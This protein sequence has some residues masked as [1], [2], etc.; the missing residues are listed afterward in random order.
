MD[1]EKIISEMSLEEKISFCTG[2]DMWH[3]KAMEKYGIEA[4]MM[5]DGPHGLRCQKNTGDNLGLNDS[6]PATC[7]PTAVTSGSSWDPELLYE[8]G[9]AIAEEALEY[10]VSTVLGPGVNIKRNPL[11]GRNFEYFSEDPHLAG[12]LAAGWIRGVQSEGVGTSLKH[13]ACN[14]QEYKRQNGNSIVDERAMHE[15]YLKPFETAVKEGHPSTVM[16]SYNQINGIYASDNRYLLT[17]VL[18]NDWG[19]DGMVVTDWGAM[20]DRI[21]GFKAGCDL[22]MPGGSKY[23]EKAVLKA[24][25]EGTLEEDDINRCLRRVLRFVENGLAGRR[26]YTFDREK[27]HALAKRIAD[28]G[29]VLLKNEGI[30]PLDKNE[31]GIIGNMAEMI[32]YQGSG[33]SHINPTKLDEIRDLWS[34]IPYA[35]GVDRY[36]NLSSIS[37]ALQIAKTKKTIVLFLGLPE[38]FESESYDRDHMRLPEGHNRLV[39]EITRVNPNVVVVLFGGSA[40]ELPW[41]DKVKTILYMGLPGQ[42]GAGSVTDILEGKVNPSGKL[43]ETWPLCYDDVIS[44]DTFG[45]KYTEYRESIFVG[46]RYYDKAG[47]NVRYPFG[48]GLSYTSF[49]YSDM[50]IKDNTISLCITNTGNM[51]GSEIVQLYVSPSDQTFRAVRELKAFRRITLKPHET[52]TVCFEI[53]DSFF[54]VY[55][56]GFV[57]AS[58]E[59][60]I[61][62]GSSSR[63]IRASVSLNVTGEDVS[64]EEYRDTWYVSLKGEPD[65]KEFENL[66]GKPVPEYREAVKGSFTMDNTCLEMKDESLMMRGVYEAVKAVISAGFPKEERTMNNPAYRMILTAAADCPLRGIVISAGGAMDENLARG[67]VDMANGKVFRNLRGM[68]RKK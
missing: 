58:G 26:E 39:E 15:I 20:H 13:F 38:S 67:L 59:Y 63:D 47:M 51:T 24:V 8:E 31:T 30:L 25:R 64:F 17:D 18:R 46:Y 66:Y 16:C 33:S 1:I 23:M 45:K 40:M 10:G 54:E 19:F 44:N 5:T 21:E 29:A 68:I 14:N 36:G 53:D 52:E 12:K 57:K 42:A 28:E 34:D 7:F 2:Q 37:A 56:D 6:L 27:H 48:H 65:K 55:R 61:A 49:A 41:A 9:K 32:R 62:A 35:E 11:G 60:T 43:T 3:T 22:N 4:V 50:K